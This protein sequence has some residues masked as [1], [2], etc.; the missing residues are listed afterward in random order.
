ME[1]GN[2]KAGCSGEELV[3]RLERQPAMKE[4]IARILDVLENTSGDLRRAADAEQR[5]IEE[6]RAMG[7]EL[8]Q[9][10]ARGQT[11]KEADRMEAGGDV[12]RQVKKTSLVQH[13]R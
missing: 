3:K 5:A 6:L 10:W 8:L 13:L 4:R 7:Q 9:G 2:W 11:Q 1:P 12:V